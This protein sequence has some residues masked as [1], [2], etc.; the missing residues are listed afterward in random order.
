MRSIGG[1]QPR[2]GAL[3]AGQASAHYLLTMLAEASPRGLPGSPVS[4]IELQRPVE[5]HP[6]NDVIVHALDED[7]AERILEIQVKRTA[8][9]APGPPVSRDVVHQLERAVRMLIRSNQRHQFVIAIEHTSFK[10]GGP[11]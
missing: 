7:G 4:G 6:L 8:T 1:E 3:F 5:G 9:F 2:A 10:A 11:Y